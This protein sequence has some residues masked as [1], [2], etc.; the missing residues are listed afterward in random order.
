MLSERLVV[1]MQYRPP[2][3]EISPA[4]KSVEATKMFTNNA[5]KFFEG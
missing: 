3:D 5:K 4:F 2:L 1:E